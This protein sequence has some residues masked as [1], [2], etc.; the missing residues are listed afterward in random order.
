MGKGFWSAVVGSATSCLSW[1]KRMEGVDGTKGERNGGALPV[2]EEASSSLEGSSSCSCL[3]RLKRME[4]V[5]GT[6]V[7]EV[8]SLEGERRLALM[9]W[10]CWGWSWGVG[11]CGCWAC[12][13]FCFLDRVL[14]E[15]DPPES[16]DPLCRV[17]MYGV[18]T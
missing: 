12:C 13:C 7:M 16:K 8:A 6:T 14:N 4:G 3:S 5:D 17:G 10:V 15:T 11:S 1:L 9:I 18:G 2:V